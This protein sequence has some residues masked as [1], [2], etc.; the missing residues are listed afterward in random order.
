MFDFQRINLIARREVTTRFRMKAYRTTLIVQIVMALVAGFLPIAISYFASDVTGGGTVL[1]VDQT[2]GDFATILN[3]N[4]QGDIPGLAA[5]EVKTTTDDID[6]VRKQVDDGDVVGAVIV[7]ENNGT[8]H[9]EVLTSGGG[10][11]DIASIRLQSAV[12]A[13]SVQLQAELSGLP[14]DEAAALVAAPAV[15]VESPEGDTESIADNFSGPIFAIVN[16]GLVLIYMMFIMYGTWVAGGVVEEKANRIMEIMVNAATPR[17]LMI[18]KILGVLIA[19]LCQTIPMLLTG[20]IAFTLQ[21]RLADLLDVNLTSAFDL[22]FSAV[23]FQ[24]VWVILV[25]FICGYAL[26]GALFAAA[27]SLVSRQEDVNQ[28]ISPML[29]LIIVGLMTSYAVMAFPNSMAAKVLFL[30][31]LTSPYVALPRILLGDPAAWEIALSIALLAVTGL[32]AMIMAGKVYRHGVLMYGQK[33]SFLNI[34]RL[35]QQQVAR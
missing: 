8:P 9:Y 18:G 11:L 29:L 20:A 28:A 34:F 4:L 23:S 25:Y 12:T 13:S 14:P 22:D 21:P 19:G 15:S 16:I 1:V 30:V 7:T 27:G 35:R 6:T 32:A 17:D 3:A 5:L 31:P 10:A 33:A 2:N 26:Y 24:A